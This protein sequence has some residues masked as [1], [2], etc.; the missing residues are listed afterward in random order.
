MR[1]LVIGNISTEVQ[2]AI[3]IAQNRGARVFFS[4]NSNEALEN[5]R[6]GQGADLVMIDAGLDICKS[7]A[8]RR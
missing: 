2:A 6:N 3:A 1:L 4:P 7:H 5:L 8:T